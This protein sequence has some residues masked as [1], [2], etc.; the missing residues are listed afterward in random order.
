MHRRT[1]GMTLILLAVVLIYDSLSSPAYAQE[2]SGTPSGPIVPTRI[3]PTPTATHTAT[4]TQTPTSTP[5]LT[6][7]NTLTATPTTPILETTREISARGGPGTNYPIVANLEAGAR[8]DILGIS[9]DGLWYQVALPDGN[10]GWLPT[11]SPLIQTAGNLSLLPVVQPPTPTPEPPTP[12]PTE[13]PSLTPT[14]EPIV[15]AITYG[16]TI[17]GLINNIS[18]ETRLTFDAAE[19]DTVDIMMRTTGGTLDPF[20]QVLDPNGDLL[21]RNDD[22]EQSPGSRD[23]HIANLTIPANGTYT[24]IATRPE[25][26][27]TQ[28]QFELTLTL[29]E[30]SQTTPSPEPTTQTVVEPIRAGTIRI[31]QAVTDTTED[32]AG[33]VAYAFQGEANSAITIT[34]VSPDFDAYLVLLDEDGA[35]LAVDDD[36]AGNRNARISDVVLPQTGIY[37]I[38][39][40]SFET[41]TANLPFSGEYTLTVSRGQGGD[42]RSTVLVCGGTVTGEITNNIFRLEY[43]FEAESGQTVT[44]AMDSA[45]GSNLDPLLI[46]LNSNGEELTRNDDRLR[47]DTNSLING[48]V[49]PADDTYTIVATRY[50]EENGDTTG[51]FIITLECSETIGAAPIQFEQVVS[52]TITNTAYTVLYSFEGEEGDVIIIN[53]TTESDQLDPYLLLLDGSGRELARNDNAADN[54]VNARISGYE[55]PADGSYLIVAGRSNNIFSSTTGDFELSLDYGSIDDRSGIFSEPIE[56][57]ETVSNEITE[58]NLEYVYTFEAQAGDVISIVMTYES[59]DLDTMVILTDN[60]GI[61]IARNDDNIFD[62]SGKLSNSAINNLILPYS[63]YYSITATRS[64]NFGYRGEGEFNLE[65]ILVDDGADVVVYAPLSKEHSTG[66]VRDGSTIT[67]Y[68]VGDWASDTT[69][70]DSEVQAFLTF[71]LPPLPEAAAIDS[72]VLDLSVCAAVGTEDN[73]RFS[74][75]GEL[76]IST[77]SFTPGRVPSFNQPSSEVLL[78]ELE[79]CGTVDVSDYVLDVIESG[80]RYVQF[81]LRFNDPIIV[82][83]ELD[84]VVFNDPRLILTTR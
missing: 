39:I 33:G 26:S 73:F 56:L 62:E 16:Q 52:G 28:G 55:L 15:R 83:A 19:G 31:G 44:I 35:E 36:S 51:E 75:L 3:T 71:Y 63:G 68:V 5:S 30:S 2:G 76:E 24:I 38:L 72:A 47:G 22:D 84:V 53:M 66:L 65:L 60:R 61:E 21:A 70:E 37:T 18:P 49:L 34:L 7:T 46:L 42:T 6:P 12:T 9:E 1:I 23:A 14:T 48:F 58:D 57:D 20:L 69:P 79:D 67:L 59:G 40:T 45:A 27:R 43:T 50:A 80:R 11:S 13:T 77:T 54:T 8:L 25:N 29:L 78:A 10:T 74:D 17:E 81:R 32:N 41:R 64:T 4:P 82:N